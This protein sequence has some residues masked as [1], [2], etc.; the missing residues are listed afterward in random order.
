MAPII[1]AIAS[2]SAC[3]DAPPCSDCDAADEVTDEATDDAEPVAD[4]PCGGA[5]LSSDPNNCGECGRVCA[6]E[7]AG[8]EWEFGG[9][10]NGEC[11]PLWSSWCR[12][13]GVLTFPTCDDYCEGTCFAQGCGGHT[14]AFY[15]PP[16]E[17]PWCFPG[18]E[19]L[20]TFDGACD[21]P[22]PVIEPP[23]AEL[24]VVTFQCC[25]DG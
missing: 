1:I 4:L 17:S 8:T 18:E 12:G 21:E 2:L 15:F 10:E 14:A 20:A 23:D 25:C 7:A 6:V 22:L 11:L 24:G 5:D 13:L 19:P 9:C 3:K 16:A